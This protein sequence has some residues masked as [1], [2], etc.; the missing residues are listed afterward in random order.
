M[1]MMTL[2]IKYRQALID[3]IYD[4]YTLIERA[5][6]AMEMNG[7]TQWD[8]LYPTKDDFLKDIRSNH[9]F[10]GCVGKQIVVVFTIN[11][12]FDIAYQDGKWKEPDKSFSIIHRFC[13][14][15]QFQNRGVAKQ[16]IDYIE[17]LV[18]LQGKQA[19]RLDVY[20]KNPYALRL[21]QSCGYQRV[22]TVE[23]RKGIFY[24]ME[25]YLY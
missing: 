22:G 16:T 23:W 13:V 24:L 4:I 3:D 17:K 1:A 12:E 7:V 15:P 11:Q 19:I 14:H 2:E 8:N 9:L 18:L 5:I 20:S 6:I 25:K 21:Y 10:V